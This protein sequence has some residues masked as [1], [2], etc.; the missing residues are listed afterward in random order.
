MENN[1]GLLLAFILSGKVYFTGLVLVFIA[2]S[3]ALGRLRDHDINFSDIPIIMVCSV[4][5]PV[6]AFM[7]CGILVIFGSVYL[8]V[9]G[10]VRLSYLVVKR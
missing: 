4:L 7:G 1:F 3:I 6:F 10:I 9:K 8:L 5:W 2:T